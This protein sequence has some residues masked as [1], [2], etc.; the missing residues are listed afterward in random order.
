VN[1]Q[2]ERN[3]E[4]IGVGEGMRRTATEM[5]KVCVMLKDVRSSIVGAQEEK[6]EDTI[7][8]TRIH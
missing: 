4:R 6:G 2:E 1:R 5:V 3:E 8:P 7:S